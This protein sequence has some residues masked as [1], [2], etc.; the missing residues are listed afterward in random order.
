M[1]TLRSLLAWTIVLLVASVLVACGSHMPN[2]Q[3]QSISISPSSASV[4]AQFTATGFYSD[5]SKVKPLLALWSDNNPWVGNDILPKIS[6]G[7]NG[8]VSCG[9]V[10]SGAY[11]IEAT[12]PSDPHIPIFQLG[13][14]TEQ[15]HGTAQLSC[16]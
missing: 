7:A 9:E 11:T 14:N 2:G 12:A 10:M 8:L 5:G 6:V 1:N 16:P 3:L 13:P 4:Q 15:V